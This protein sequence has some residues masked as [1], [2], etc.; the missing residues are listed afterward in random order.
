MQNIILNITDVSYTVKNNELLS[1]NHPKQILKNISFE[2][3]REKIYGLTGESGSGK[4]TLAKLLADIYKPSTGFIENNFKKDWSESLPKPIQ[5]LFQ[6]DGELLNPNRKVGDILTEAFELKNNKKNDYSDLVSKILSKFQFSENVKNQKGFQLSGG[7]QQ[8][9]ALARIY[10]VEPEVLIL[11]E[12]FSSQ[13][14]EAQLNIAGLIKNL[15]E[16]LGLTV[17]CISHDLDIL[18]IIC[19]D[20]IVMSDG[21]IVESGSTHNIFNNPQKEY[22]KFLLSAKSLKLSKQE[23]EEF[24]K[25]YEQN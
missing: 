12:P 22:T 9:I 24:V 8:R 25:K 6:N 13:D 15:K 5:I 4:T 18:K 10:I 11:D 14:I 1:T 23:I 17:I 16:E 3:V 19:Q 21:K 20:I 2:F 7:E